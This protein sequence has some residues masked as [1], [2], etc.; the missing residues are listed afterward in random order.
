MPPNILLPTFHDPQNTSPHKQSLSLDY[1]Q[2]PPF[3]LS[4]QA[5]L[6]MPNLS[7]V[8]ALKDSGTAASVSPHQLHET[9]FLKTYMIAQ[10]FC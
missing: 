10:S 4:H 3:D 7:R 6:C 8:S 1:L 9:P 2:G 5:Y